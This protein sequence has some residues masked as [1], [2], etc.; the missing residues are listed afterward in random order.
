MCNK[1]GCSIGRGE[2]EMLLEA[3]LKYFLEE[4]ET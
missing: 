1:V 3:E 2:Q 4:K